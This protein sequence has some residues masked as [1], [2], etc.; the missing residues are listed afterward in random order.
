MPEEFRFSPRPNRAN[1]IEWREWG[2]KPFAEALLDNKLV[3]LAISGVWCHW[4]HVMDETTYSD[5][6]VIELINRNFI[7]VRV[8]TD[9]R[10]DV[11]QRYNLG[12]W[13]TTALL[14]PR[15]ELLSGGTYIPPERMKPWL[16][17]MAAAYAR[18][19]GRLRASAIMPATEEEAPAEGPGPDES[20]ATAGEAVA[21]AARTAGEVTWDIYY[22]VLEKVR[23]DYDPEHAGFG[24]APKFPM[25]EAL[26]LA[27]DGF[28]ATR[29]GK[30]RGIFTLT[31]LAM[32]R[33]GMY[34]PVEGGFFRY[35]TTRDWSVPHYEK[36]LEDNALL[37][38]ALVR[39]HRLDGNPEFKNIARDVL[40]Y[41]RN[42]LYLPETGGWA[43]SQDADEEYYALGGEARR[44][45]RPPYVDRTIYVNWNALLARS[46][47]QAGAVLADESLAELASRTLHLLMERCYTKE[48][49]MAH[50]LLEDGN[51]GE[52]WGLL[53][54][55]VATGHALLTG[56]QHTGHRP[57]LDQS[58]SLADFCLDRLSSPEGAL[59]DAPPD[60]EAPGA[61]ARPLRDFRQNALA[62]RW[63]LE[64]ATLTG[65]DSYRRSGTRILQVFLPLYHERGLH[66]S[67]YALAVA[68]LKRP[69][70][71]VDVVG[72]ADDP[73]TRRLARAALITYRPQK[74]VRILDPAARRNEVE[75]MGYSTEGAPRAHVCVGTRCLPPTQEVWA[76]ESA[77]NEPLHMME[78]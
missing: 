54:D 45:R 28:F 78:R 16:Q 5:P 26:E 19:P 47:F 13:P 38:G 8:D 68:D 32:A 25:T 2:E 77:L 74:A 23:E 48:R 75:A 27:M 41:L 36:M 37:L 33:G 66:A 61:L 53:A 50:Y 18:D 1:L 52:V 40:R 59:F 15:G 70:A 71:V 17:E 43:G 30:L 9:R 57:W 12:G 72:P 60:P 3:L 35:S 7:P 42:N 69:W 29:E 4:C 55:Q 10:P 46:L 58:L 6:Q 56:Y 73:A 63:L 22:R 34:D 44:Q 51:T 20:P 67:G 65:E 62:A 24:T 64:L 39:A 76:I 49:G 14:T 21:T 31:L 11:N